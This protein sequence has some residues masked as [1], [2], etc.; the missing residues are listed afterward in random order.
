MIVKPGIGYIL[1]EKNHSKT[2]SEQKKL[3]RE[4][5]WIFTEKNIMLIKQICTCT[6]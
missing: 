6:R 5:L 4:K 3:K 1:S 2:F